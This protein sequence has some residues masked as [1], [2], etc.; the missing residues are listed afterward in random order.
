MKYMYLVHVTV[1]KDGPKHLFLIWPNLYKI[2]EETR[3]V[4]ECVRAADA[5]GYEMGYCSGYSGSYREG[6]YFEEIDKALTKKMQLM[7]AD[8][9]TRWDLEIEVEVRL[10]VPDDVDL[11]RL[12]ANQ[13]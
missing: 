10:R 6:Q 11:G 4:D 9:R 7:Y 3:T 13:R 1:R 5:K 8:V 12:G 2:T